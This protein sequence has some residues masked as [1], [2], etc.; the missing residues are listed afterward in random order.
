MYIGP[1][2]EYTLSK[3]AK[4]SRPRPV[5]PDSLRSDIE[6][7]LASS[8]D[9]LSA[10][11]ALS[12]ISNTLLTQDA[13][14][15][16]NPRK[17]RGYDP[18]ILTDESR[19][20]TKEMKRQWDHNS[21]NP[22]FKMDSPVGRLPYIDG[23]RSMENLGIR[24]RNMQS[25]DQRIQGHLSARDQR[26]FVTPSPISVRS[27]KSEPNPSSVSSYPS[28]EQGVGGKKLAN[29]RPRGV[30]PLELDKLP[31]IKP[32]RR[33]R[34]TEAFSTEASSDKPS[35]SGRGVK[36]SDDFN[37]SSYGQINKSYNPHAAVGLLR[38]E[39]NN[40]AR[41]KIADI[42]GWNVNLDNKKNDHLTQ[43][44][45]YNKG[46]SGD[47]VGQGEPKKEAVTVEEKL[48]Q[49][50]AMKDMYMQ[51]R[52]NE[53]KARGQHRN[54]GGIGSSIADE[55]RNDVESAHNNNETTVKEM[56][57]NERELMS[58]SK[59]FQDP[60]VSNPNKQVSENRDRDRDRD[61]DE[62]MQSQYVQHRASGG[63]SLRDAGLLSLSSQS[64]A[65]KL[66]KSRSHLQ[67]SGSDGEAQAQGQGQGK[68]SVA[69]PRPTKSSFVATIPTPTINTA[70]DD[71]DDDEYQGQTDYRYQV[72]ADSVLHAKQD[73]TSSSRPLLRSQN[74]RVGTSGS[75]SGDEL[76]SP[77]IAD[78]LLKWSKMLNLD[79]F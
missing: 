19:L 51:I 67:G 76:F 58:I 42:T 70:Y 18:N 74:S 64:L 32:P 6:K 47:H 60:V 25:F 31:H 73:Y 54:E 75:T 13:K 53:A 78:D 35:S 45:A 59:Y 16:S 50:K 49:V 63:S 71:S 68:S 77:G 27:T 37:K 72:Q 14:N 41:N 79:D 44:I 46:V 1:W 38:M 28:G 20:F 66:A 30:A 12:A 4:Q 39:R 15:T 36:E 5:I 43:L 61:K 65:D 2:Q 23:D 69:S 52:Q 10:Q 9:P 48:E 7:A 21:Q 11:I 29:G 40:R 24:S 56:D 33:R 8:L 57:L 17:I 26:E 55:T 22:S 3:Q 62:S 34:V